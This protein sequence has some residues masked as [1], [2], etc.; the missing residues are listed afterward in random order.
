MALDEGAAA[1]G[2]FAVGYGLLAVVGCTFDACAVFGAG[3]FVGDVGGADFS[4]YCSEVAVVY[5]TLSVALYCAD[6]LTPIYNVAFGGID[7]DVCL[8]REGYY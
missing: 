8:C 6:Q 3:L 2:A 7:P 1:A 5:S 4:C